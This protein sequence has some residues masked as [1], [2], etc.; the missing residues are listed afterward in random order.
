MRW[1]HKLRQWRRAVSNY[2]PFV[3]V[4][5]SRDSIEHNYRAYQE[6]L[7]GHKIA[8]VLKSNAYGHGLV[9][10]SEIVDRFSPPFIAVDSLYEA[11]LLRMVNIKAPLLVIG[12][13]LPTN[14]SSNHLHD[15]A[16][17]VVGIEH[18]RDLV[19]AVI[20]PA[21]LHIKFDT[22]MHRQGLLPEEID[23]AISL[24]KQNH[25]L[26]V[27]GIMSHLC[28]ADGDNDDFT[29]E[30][31]EV[32]KK[33]VAEWTH[34][35]GEVKWQ[36]ISA[37]K[38]FRF[39]TEVPGNLIRLGIGL[40]GGT[41]PIVVKK[42]LRLALKMETEISA[43]RALPDGEKIGY[44]ITYQTHR[45]TRVATVPVGYFE[46][47]DRRLSNK[48]F[49]LVNG[50]P[51]PIVGRVSMNITSI[52]VTDINC[53]AGDKVTVIDD[54]PNSENSVF[55]IANKANTIPYEILVHIPQH[56]RREVI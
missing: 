29:R 52:D 18:L 2:E 11:R 35:F 7:P 43:V 30:Q 42:P 9:E 45:K 51:C 55:K 23:L 41:N 22:G 31:L 19:K 40:Y 27:E 36:H 38:G 49:F 48:G 8:P 47:V 17:T 37:T 26:E 24:I 1:L 4:F 32:W 14:V 56:L 20:F 12:Y 5:I 46:G 6:A 3:K 15:I 25:N 10:V 28:D 54:N 33:V 13:S 16:F 39:A 34:K 44:N 53:K 21:K 50:E